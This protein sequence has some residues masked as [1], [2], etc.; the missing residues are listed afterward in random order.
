M[1]IE[2]EIPEAH[3]LDW[4][5]TCDDCLDGLHRKCRRRRKCA[6]SAC[7]W[8][9]GVRQKAKPIYVPKVDDADEIRN[10]MRER[11]GYFTSKGNRCGRVSLRH[12]YNAVDDEVCL[13]AHHMLTVEMKR[14]S[15]IAKELNVDRGN[16]TRAMQRRD[17]YPKKR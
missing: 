17:L 5:E 1:L 16:L 14:I 9:S 11:D 7:A 2:D 15:V 13:Q 8:L 12:N 10:A 3:D 4:V 6:C